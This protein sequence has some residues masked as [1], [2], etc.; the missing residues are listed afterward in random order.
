MKITS[1]AVAAVHAGVMIRVHLRYGS[2]EVIRKQS[3]Q[4]KMGGQQG[5][6]CIL[7]LLPQGA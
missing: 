1:G 7:D 2:T 4:W 5:I 3:I 6:I